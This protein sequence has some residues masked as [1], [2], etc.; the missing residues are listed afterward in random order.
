MEGAKASAAE[1]ARNKSAN[2]NAREQLEERSMNNLHWRLT[3]GGCCAAAADETARYSMTG[4]MWELDGNVIRLVATDG[5]RLALSEGWRAQSHAA[6]CQSAR[7]VTAPPLTDMPRGTGH[8]S[9]SSR[10]QER[11][12]TSQLGK[13]GQYRLRRSRRAVEENS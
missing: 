8:Q 12:D 5:R 9:Q 3:G 2:A 6:S 4:V 13:T 10:P 11:R 7:E 1:S